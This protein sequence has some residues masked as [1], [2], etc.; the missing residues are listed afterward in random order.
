ME[1][2]APSQPPIR[3][4]LTALEAVNFALQQ[5]GVQLIRR[6]TLCNDSSRSLENVTLQVTSPASLCL[7]LHKHFDSLPAHTSINAGQLDLT[8]DA[9]KLATMTESFQDTL[10]VSLIQGADTLW[11]G[12]LPVT[13]LAYDQWH[14]Y[15]RYPELLA[16][17]V[18][19]NHPAVAQIL[20]RAAQLLQKWSGDPSL[21]GYQ[22]QDPNR[23]LA[24][25]AAIYGAIQEQNIVYCVPPASFEE[26]GQ[27]VRLCDA[28]LQQKLAT[29]LDISLFYAGCLEAA[30]LHPLLVLRTGHIFCGLW[31]EDL[32][33]PESIQDDASLLTKRL[34]SGI[35]EI[36]VVECTAMSAGKDM[37]FDSA[38][39]DA[40]N[41]L[42]GTDP[43]VYILD[44]T[45]ARLSGV[46]P[47][48]VRIATARGWEFPRENLP[49]KEL[50]QAPEGLTP[51]TQ[52]SEEAPQ[53]MGKMA[54][55]ERKLLDLGLR[56]SLINMRLRSTIVP[57]L[58]PSLDELENALSSGSDFTVLPRPTDMTP[59]ETPDFETMHRLA[60]GN[61][62]LSSE[63]SA[64]RLRSSYEEAPLAK[65][66]KELY[67]SGK[68]SLEEN[69]A[70]T[71]YLALGLLRW[72]ET[73]R[74]SKARY[75]PL[76]LLPI[77]MVRRSACAGYAIR[78]RDEDP[79]M[80][81]TMLEKLKQDFGI[82]I[83]GLDPLP[84]DERGV[85]IRQVFNAIRKA[86]MNQ[87]RWD[88]LESAWL[89]IFSF[90]QFVMW[91][92]LRNRS[93][94][95]MKNKIVRSLIDGKL[96]WEAQPMTLGSHVSDEG[97]YLPMSADASQLFAI[98][99]A[100][101]GESFV[102]HGPPG[103]GKSQT[104]TTLIANA[105]AQGKS[106]LFVAEK[107]A[108]LE[109]VRKRLAKI[110]IGDFCLELHSNKAKKRVVLDQ[111]RRASEVKGG[112][113]SREYA[114][115][116]DQL[117]ALRREL[118]DYAQALHSPNGCGLTLYDTVCLY[119]ENAQAPDT[120]AMTREFVCGLTAGDLARHKLLLEQ[121]VC[122]GRALPHPHGHPLSAVGSTRYSQRL[123][124]DLSPAL[125]A[126]RSAIY[127]LTEPAKSLSELTGLEA[128]TGRGLEVLARAAQTLQAWLSLPRP[129]AASQSPQAL[130]ADAREMAR[131]F[132]KAK[133]LEN[134]LLTRWKPDFLTLDGDVLL[135]EWEENEAKWFL[136]KA[137][138][139]RRLLRRVNLYA[140]SP[141]TGEALPREL[142]LL[143]DCRQERDAGQALLDRCG[144]D[145]GLLYQ[146]SATD[147]DRVLSAGEQA[148]R[149]LPELDAGLRMKLAG[150]A[151]F[152]APIEGFLAA[153]EPFRIARQGLYDLLS[154]SQPQDAP[155]YLAGELALCARLDMN[156]DSLKDFI[157]FNAA[158]RDAEETGLASIVEAYRKGMAH[159]Q[160]LPAYHKAL[161]KAMAIQ[162][163]DESPALSLFSGAVFNE[164]IR[165]LEQLEN[166][167]MRLAREE[168]FCRLAARVPDFTREAAHSSELGILQRAI[169]SGGRGVSIRKLL[170]QL[171]NLLP[172]LCPCM[173]MSPISA[174][175]YL[176]PDR[177][178]FDTVV[179]DEA[180]QLP[181]AK[182]VGALAR[183][184][185]AVIVGD[186]KQMPPTSFFI[187]NQADE[188]N[189]DTEDL[190]SILDDCLALNLPQ[191]HLLWHYRSRH[192]SLI[193]FSNANFYENKLY[194]FPSVNDRISK[195]SLVHVEGVFQRSKTRQ[196][197]AEAQAIVEELKRRCH[198]EKES[199]FSVGVVTFNIHQQHLIDDLLSEACRLDPQL[200]AW[201]YQGEEPVF[202][203][204]LENVQ[205]DERDVILF[206]VGYGPDEQGKVY[207]NFGP[208]N[209][210]GGWRRLNVAITRA[211]Q[212]MK[213][214]ATLQPEQIDLT[215]T[216][217]QGVAALR[218][219][220]EY[221]RD[222]TLPME[223][224]AL[225]GGK[226]EPSGIADSIC[227]ALED[228]GY[229]VSRNV[230]HSQYRIDVAVADPK[231]PDRYCL[232][233]VL[234]GRSYGAARTTRDRETA[235][236]GVL[237]G[238]GWRITRVWT[239]DW[240]DNPQ[241]ELERLLALLKKPVAREKVQAP[242]L[243]ELPNILTENVPKADDPHVYTFARLPQAQVSA[244]ELLS[245]RY[246]PG[247][248]KRIII[249]LDREA[250][251][252]KAAMVRRIVQSYGI[253]RAG[254]R[255]GAH[256]D[257]LLDAMVLKTTRQGDQTFYW[258]A[259][260]DPENYQLWRC[261]PD[262]ESRREAR[263]IPVEE[264]AAAAC[265]ALMDQLSLN[266]EDLIREGAKLLGFPRLGSAIT[267]LMEEAVRYGQ[268]KNRIVIAPNGSYTLPK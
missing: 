267:A 20:G 131:R 113:S 139:Q 167:L 129:W 110:G 241:R 199:N 162:T 109:V 175:Q 218:A 183:G 4:A 46:K 160:V 264:A 1:I 45:R 21:D 239:M 56:N 142:R 157:A 224:E 150:D 57:L 54:L 151:A 172:R 63:F 250:P 53:A 19:P 36:A 68:S 55:W 228:G 194:T 207:M 192:E 209:R 92:D 215:R 256:L 261:A 247:I 13:V 201:V 96:A 198:D 67:R 225:T 108:A 208:L 77:E 135:R 84:M 111:L 236:I 122:A 5:N 28:I 120:P 112:A 71:L 140:L 203:K 80:N 106:V 152:A 102:L 187:S 174:A 154:I 145:L 143:R 133:A 258:R 114:A 146:G 249:L 60:A 86:V 227:D 59:E 211:R 61:Q 170:T 74:S 206:S 196:N 254:S 178:P 248:R 253:A 181:T 126:Y 95:L 246:T 231:A 242:A 252:S 116:A 18:T 88:V 155:E 76:V 237:Q 182:A 16:S 39:A 10:A 103:T 163:I 8:L 81:V 266:R 191:T 132:Q 205:G 238:L 214:F 3:V 268:W 115:R 33:F 179:F 125:D 47:L 177:A 251:I 130:I 197:R 49:E 220:L 89:G 121:L 147:C 134:D 217:A 200:D 62:L 98:G 25:A 229:Q 159:S 165:Q 185:N 137:L 141:V 161:Y 124:Y 257:A 82:L 51:Q 226:P 73:D 244:E 153:W 213:V 37:S 22:T 128:S 41:Q 6:A 173:L 65:S 223:P 58:T 7:P 42:T 204:N 2:N 118:D 17:F 93:A 79:Q 50:T 104:I 90:S 12:S 85:D 70:N 83:S 186:P 259:D 9:Q 235:Q 29:C 260:Q 101:Q 212:E 107:M 210:D 127:G 66:M 35:N 27:R 34:A 24:Q 168:I 43:I 23:V 91:N 232:G 233:I 138:G 255:I 176:E 221:A 52:V 222:H 97:V 169:R 148:L 30:G 26:S 234:D 195:V 189:L 75:A 230:G 265:Q 105:L 262:E 144:R 188:D 44:V 119:Q 263:E 219:F 202:I 87:P 11:A 100:A 166:T 15:G 117:H 193:A 14:G 164:K 94:D 32:T 149:L 38:Q 99:K 156:R 245:S 40:R 72:Y 78:L 64:K 171:P 243:P 136:P 216:G 31:L 123:R 180:S 184:E 48:P 158:A 69:G 240:W 190:E